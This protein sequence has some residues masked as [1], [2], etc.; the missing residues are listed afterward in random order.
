MIVDRATWLP[1]RV[2]RSYRGTVVESWGL[3]DVHLDAPL[4][5]SDFS[6]QLPEQRRAD[7]R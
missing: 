2:V 1:V 5:A 3:R 7:H 6:V 4:L